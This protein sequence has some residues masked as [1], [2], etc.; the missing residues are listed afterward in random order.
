MNLADP[1]RGKGPWAR[2]RAGGGGGGG[3]GGDVDGL[4]KI[5]LQRFS[6]PLAFVAAENEQGI[7]KNCSGRKEHHLQWLKSCFQ[8]P[9][10]RALLKGRTGE[11]AYNLYATKTMLMGHCRTVLSATDRSPL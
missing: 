6:F 11:L 2:A 10:I 9:Y 4:A 8:I 3:W 7:K 1:W 5:W